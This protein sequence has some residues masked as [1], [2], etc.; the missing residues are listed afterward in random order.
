MTSTDTATNKQ[1]FPLQ[2]C[3]RC[4]GTGRYSYNAIHGSKCFGCGGTGWKIARRA[5]SAWIAYRDSVKIAKNPTVGDL[6]PGDLIRWG[7]GQEWREVASVEIDKSKE[8]GWSVCKG[9]RIAGAWA[10]VV[11]YTDGTTKDTS[12]HFIVDR[13]QIV[14][15]AAFLAAIPQPRRVKA[16]VSE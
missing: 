8:C 12:T 16:Q 9:E 7:T 2:H 14:D 4:G 1:G 5:A 10:A 15:P 6:Q 3:G 13:N 11:T